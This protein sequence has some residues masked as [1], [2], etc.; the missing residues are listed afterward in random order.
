M[1]M[2]IE[3]ARLLAALSLCL[4][5]SHRGLNR[6]HQRVAMIVLNLAE[7]LGLSREEKILCFTSAI[8]HDAGI[9]TWRE[10][11]PLEAFDV[12]E[13]WEHCQR[14][15][16]LLA[17]VDFLK[18]AAGII[19][20][21]HDRWQ[22]PNPSGRAQEEIPLAA[23]LIHLA[24][25]LDIS[26][27]YERCMLDQREDALQR[28]KKLSGSIFD[29]GLVRVLEELA[30]K[31][32]FW[33]DLISPF[34]EK[35]LIELAAPAAALKFGPAEL[36]QVA[37]LFAA[38]IDAKSTFTYLHSRRVAAVAGFLGREMGFREEMAFLEIAGLL[39]DLGKLCI[40]DEILEKPAPLTGNE[41]NVIKQ[42]AYYTY[43]I[44]EEAG[45]LD[46]LPGWAGYHHE[47]L[48]GRGYPF[49]LENG[50]LSLPARVMAV[51]DIFTA[52]REDRPYRPGMGRGQI[53]AI[54]REHKENGSLDAKVVD[55]C[56]DNFAQLADLAASF[57]LS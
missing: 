41:Y 55:A 6:H 48:N 17:Q 29:P 34:M 28:I 14:G 47:K 2:I 44:L 35:R 11:Q 12:D 1:K 26:L 32:S 49:H 24:D 51:S 23:R 57:S 9:S 21:H 45:N 5:F 52:L 4:D 19:F 8:V 20:S 33:F 16:R 3:P 31:E 22:G 30:R 25:R 18:P 15:S 46:P 10:K 38:V 56:L 54:L 7:E 42:H 37:G 39:H 53:E 27:Q 36:R 43:R 50:Q 13:P 40:P